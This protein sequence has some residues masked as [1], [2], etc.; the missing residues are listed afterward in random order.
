MLK[1][2]CL[3]VVL[4]VL[5]ALPIALP[6]QS[7]PDSRQQTKSE[8]FAGYSY[9]VRDYRHTQLNPVSGGMS[10]W[11]AAWTVP[12]LFGSHLGLTADFSGH[13]SSGGF[14]TPQIYFL[15]AGPQFSV[16]AGRGKLYMHG[17]VGTLVASTDVI[18]Q[19]SS[20][21]ALLVTAGGGF[22]YPV[23]RRFSWRFNGDYLHGGFKSNDTNQISQIVD[24]N[25][26]F[27]TGP[28]LHF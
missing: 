21:V 1:S 16:P 28:V 19:T 2:N 15:S 17:L 3:N 13:Y 23:G 6:A 24:N 18:A 8:L 5:L 10:G 26:R 11:N 14:F 27:S 4:L 9:V 22:D 20:H 12:A 7:T 25:F